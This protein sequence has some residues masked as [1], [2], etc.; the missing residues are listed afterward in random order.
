ME[1]AAPARHA[2]APTR[3][4][5]TPLPVQVPLMVDARHVGESITPTLGRPMGPTSGQAVDHPA[6]LEDAAM[7]VALQGEVALEVDL[8]VS[9]EVAMDPP[10]DSR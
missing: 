9:M 10:G 6:G 1:G 3:A 4:A 5:A 8:G 7:E 2:A